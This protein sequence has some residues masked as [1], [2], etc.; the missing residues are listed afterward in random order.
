MARIRTVKPEFWTDAKTGLLTEFSKCLFLGLLNHADDYGVLEWE[1]ME[2]RAKIFPYH[3]DTTTGAVQK[4]LVEELLPRGLVV[5]FG[6]TDD[7]GEAR[8]YLLIR[9][10]V[11]HQVINKPSKPLLPDWKKSDTPE[12]YAKRRG[13][14][15]AELGADTLGVVRQHSDTTTVALL[16]G[17]ERKGKDS[18]PTGL[19]PDGVGQAEKG[20]N[21]DPPVTD[22]QTADAQLFARG[23]EVLGN[24]K[25]VGGLIT[26][27]KKH[28]NGN[29]A[30]ARAAIETASTKDKPRE[31]IGAIVRGKRE[32]EADKSHLIAGLWDPGI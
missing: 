14:A 29:I 5:L 6:R 23:R 24:V 26:E 10:F 2:W 1:P 18:V 32:H 3:S 7:Q 17:K 21:P 4:S 9:N 20:S 19:T 27:L 8:R 12:T 30:L 31:Y 25:G 11:K 15:F 16:P 28:F 13:E 22:Q